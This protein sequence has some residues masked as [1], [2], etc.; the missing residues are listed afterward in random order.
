VDGFD[1]TEKG[2]VRLQGKLLDACRYLSSADLI[3]KSARGTV[4]RVQGGQDTQT[5]ANVGFGG[6]LSRPNVRLDGCI[7]RRK[8]RLPGCDF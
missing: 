7:S 4:F 2:R 5:P 3:L 8:V 6:A 1:K